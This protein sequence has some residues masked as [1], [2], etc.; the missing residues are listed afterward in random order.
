MNDPGNVAGLGWRTARVLEVRCENL[1]TVYIHPDD[2]NGV[3]IDDGGQT[4]AYL[5]REE[6]ATYIPVA[7]LDLTAIRKLLDA[8][9]VEWVDAPPG[10]YPSIACRVRPGQSIADAVERVARAI[11]GVFYSALRPD[12]K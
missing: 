1:E 5:C 7:T 4:F 2:G 3:R 8:L 6:N 11:D 10:G 9:A 12:L